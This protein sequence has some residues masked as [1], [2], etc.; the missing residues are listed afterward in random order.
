MEQLLFY[1][2]GSGGEMT[3]FYVQILTKGRA[4]SIV[5][6][7]SLSPDCGVYSKALKTEKL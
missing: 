3:R 4:N 2:P 7:S 6:T 1:C 5:L